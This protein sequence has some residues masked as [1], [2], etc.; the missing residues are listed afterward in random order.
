[1]S[2]METWELRSDV[3]MK[4]ET[5]AS[6]V[7]VVGLSGTAEG[8]F[9]TTTTTTVGLAGVRVGRRRSYAS[10]GVAFFWLCEQAKNTPDR[11]TEISSVVT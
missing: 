6:V 9:S 11:E 4:R 10:D 1:M 2:G 5:S 7:I 8:M 3:A